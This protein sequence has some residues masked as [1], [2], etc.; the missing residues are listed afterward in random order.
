MSGTKS[1]LPTDRAVR[2][3][4]RLVHGGALRSPFGETSEAL[5]LTQGYVYDT[6]E[7]AEARFRNE[8]PGY[9]YSRFAN[10]TVTMFEERMALLEEAESA[11]ATAT[12]MAARCARP[13]AR[14]PKRCI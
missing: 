13:S 6:M 3:A 2:P 11:R 4:T 8:Q 12:G 7:S 5:Y 10:P 1:P 9:V 14:P